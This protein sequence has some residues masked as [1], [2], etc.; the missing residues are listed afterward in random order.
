MGVWWWGWLV[1]G[2]WVGVVGGVGG[3]CW[4][5]SSAGTLYRGVVFCLAKVAVGSGMGVAAA[6]GAHETRSRQVVSSNRAVRFIQ[7]I[8]PQLNGGGRGV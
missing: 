5:G 1:G 3:V 2:V 8:K 4:G 7:A 6:G